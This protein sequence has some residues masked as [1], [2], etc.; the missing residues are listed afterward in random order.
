MVRHGLNDEEQILTFQVLLSV[1][2]LVSLASHRL[3]LARPDTEQPG[4][5]EPLAAG[6]LTE[7]P[8]RYVE[9]RIRQETAREFHHFLEGLYWPRKGLTE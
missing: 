6:N 5:T 9:R 1:N 4:N 8:H 7:S 3:S 2:C